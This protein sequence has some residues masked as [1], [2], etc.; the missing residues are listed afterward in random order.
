MA[1]SGQSDQ[2]KQKF[3]NLQSGDT[4]SRLERAFR[5]LV[6]AAR[7]QD[8]RRAQFKAA[9]R[10]LGFAWVEGKAT[11]PATT[12]R[13][14]PLPTSV[15][16]DPLDEAFSFINQ[17]FP[18]VEFYLPYITAKARLLKHLKAGGSLEPEPEYDEDGFLSS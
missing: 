17:N 7:P 1:K 6:G 3:P 13:A 8:F 18:E 10:E 15:E 5:T 16:G 14:I 12:G 9:L 2:K 4:D 11:N